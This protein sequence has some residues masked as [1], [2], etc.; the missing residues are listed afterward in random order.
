[1]SLSHFPY[2]TLT[3]FVEYDQGLSTNM[4]ARILF[5]MIVRERRRIAVLVKVASSLDERVQEAEKGLVVRD[6]ALRSSLEDHRQDVAD[7]EQRQHDQIICLVDMVTESADGKDIE[8]EGDLRSVLTFQK[9]L[10]VLANERVSLCVHLLLT[11]I[12]SYVLI[13]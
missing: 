11:F 3:L 9:K 6:A 8:F 4:A 12:R 2:L 7:L 13:L 10:L 5:G 1:L